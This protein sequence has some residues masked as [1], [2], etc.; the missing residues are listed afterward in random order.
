MKHINHITLSSG[1]IR[2]T[3]PNEVDKE[4]YFILKRLYND[5]L[6]KEVEIFDGY[7]MKT[8]STEIGTLITV[9]NAAKMPIL[10]TAISKNDT[11]E[12]WEVLHE[13]A[14][15]PLKTD[16]GKIPELPYIADRL[17][18]GA[19]F[20]LAATKWTGA[21]SRCMGWIVLYPKA[22]YGEENKDEGSNRKRN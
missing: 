2:K 6:K 11:G 1:H 15:T 9:Y 21:F 16:K 12:L 19:M 20:D 7:T 10:T 18:L 13:S 3:S 14:T 5:S 8:T 22:V 4:L 17:E